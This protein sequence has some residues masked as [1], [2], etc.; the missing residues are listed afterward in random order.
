MSGRRGESGDG[1]CCVAVVLDC[2]R[3]LDVFF[4]VCIISY[5]VGPP[6]FVKI[7]R[8][9]FWSSK[10]CESAWTCEINPKCHLDDNPL[11]VLWSFPLCMSFNYHL[12]IITLPGSVWYEIVSI[13]Y[14]IYSFI[15][16]F[17]EACLVVARQV[18]CICIQNKLL[19]GQEVYLVQL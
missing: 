10:K 3:K 12:K 14:C 4:S 9:S 11:N 5:S 16:Y 18:I 17:E 8:A 7:V 15:F 2:K 1:V 6:F 13:K 19:L